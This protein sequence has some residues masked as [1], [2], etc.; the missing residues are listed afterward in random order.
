LKKI[1]A[2]IG[3]I[4]Q[5]IA[6]IDAQLVQLNPFQRL[7]GFKKGPLEWLS[8]GNTSS[9]APPDPTL[10]DYNQSFKAMQELMSEHLHDPTELSPKR[11][12]EMVCQY[13]REMKHAERM[14]AQIRK[15]FKAF[16]PK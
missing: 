16:L 10:N 13:D 1:Q 7:L 6:Q 12:S 14:A 5:H 3:L 4:D 2:R 8:R 9:E 15:H 11:L